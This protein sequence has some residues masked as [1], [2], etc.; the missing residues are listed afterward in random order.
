MTV[1][2]VMFDIIMV[3]GPM[4]FLGPVGLLNILSILPLV[5]TDHA[6]V[7]VYYISYIAYLFLLSFK[8][9]Y[10]RRVLTY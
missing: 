8:V 2:L 1:F 5:L 4:E 10:T 9:Y 3:L 6:G 7:T